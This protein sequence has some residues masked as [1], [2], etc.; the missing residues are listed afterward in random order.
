MAETS[1]SGENT[2]ADN[3]DASSDNLAVSIIYEDK[4]ALQDA[5]TWWAASQRSACKVAQSNASRYEVKCTD[6]SCSF[7]F[8]SHRCRS[9]F[10][11][12]RSELVHSAN[13]PARPRRGRTSYMQQLSSTVLAFAEKATP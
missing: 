7:D 11:V 6:E 1:W 8:K 10:R 2:T 5:F 12:A 9:G 4:K 13:C 3:A